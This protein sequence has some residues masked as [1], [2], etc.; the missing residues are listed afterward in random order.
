MS[1]I[2]IRN[3][4]EI[5]DEAFS[6]YSSLV[7]F[8]LKNVKKISKNIFLEC[9]ALKTI[10]INGNKNGQNNNYKVIDGKQVYDKSNN[11]LIVDLS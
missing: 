4:E 3:T 5:Y 11:S 2:D 7:Q 1:S 6:G 10:L 9:E 8:D